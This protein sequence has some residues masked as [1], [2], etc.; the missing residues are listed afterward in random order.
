MTIDEVLKAG[1]SE[2]IWRRANNAWG[3]ERDIHPESWSKLDY[4]E[5]MRKEIAEELKI[6]EAAPPPEPP[7]PDVT[8]EEFF[9]RKLAKAKAE[10]APMA[11]KGPTPRGVR[12]RREFL[13]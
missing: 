7:E 12:P 1:P 4:G 10:T 11:P 8:V 5:F 13:K 6:A 2:V 9:A 3:R